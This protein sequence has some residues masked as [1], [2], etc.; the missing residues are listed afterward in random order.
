LIWHRRIEIPYSEDAWMADITMEYYLIP[1][2]PVYL[3]G[4]SGLQ[5]I[6]SERAFGFTIIKAQQVFD[7]SVASLKL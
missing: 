7:A 6:S 2:R 4:T 1:I 5:E 3:D